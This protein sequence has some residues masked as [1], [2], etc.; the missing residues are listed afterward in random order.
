MIRLACGAVIA[1][2][3]MA[4]AFGAADDRQPVAAAFGVLVSWVGLY[5]IWRWRG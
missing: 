4:I 1:L 5:L 3:G 2:G